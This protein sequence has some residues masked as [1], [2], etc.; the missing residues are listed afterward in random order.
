MSQNKSRIS[1]KK[2]LRTIN[3]G[4]PSTIKYFKDKIKSI[5]EKT[6]RNLELTTVNGSTI[7]FEDIDKNAYYQGKIYRA[8]SGSISEIKDIEKLEIYD[9]HRGKLLSEAY[10]NLI[11]GISKDDYKQANNAFNKLKVFKFRNSVTPNNGNVICKDGEIHKITI[12]EQF[13]I[14]AHVLKETFEQFI[15]DKAFKDEDDEISSIVLAEDIELK[16]TLKKVPSKEIMEVKIALERERMKKA[17]QTPEFVNLIFEVAKL[18]NEDK[19]EEAIIKTSSY[20]SEEQTLLLLTESELIDTIGYALATKG[21]FNDTIGYHVANVISE[22]GLQTNKK[23][24][25]DFW[26]DVDAQINNKKIKSLIESLHQNNFDE[27]YVIMENTIGNLD[28]KKDLVGVFINSILSFL[29]N[30]NLTKLVKTGDTSIEDIKNE[31]SDLRDYIEDSDTNEL[32]DSVVVKLQEIM[33][34]FD[35]LNRHKSLI[36]F[37]ETIAPETEEETGPEGEA[38]EIP[39]EEGAAVGMGAGLTGAPG[40]PAIGGDDEFEIGGEEEAETKPEEEEEEEELK[41]GESIK[42]LRGKLKY[43]KENKEEC[44]GDEKFHDEIN[45]HINECIE[46]DNDGIEMLQEFTTLREEY[47]TSKLSP[48]TQKQELG[49]DEFPFENYSDHVDIL[50]IEEI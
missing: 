5:G 23:D 43:I 47:V 3:S 46:L 21:V 26:Q 49:R 13:N 20:I 4:M 11:E 36:N 44:F 33:V 30:I 28:M 41:M 45:K 1:I 42:H 31:F 32:D 15:E 8:E 18:I 14:N 27:Y 39:A 35:I 38:V 16:E 7:I 34:P 37:D 17:Y 40:A 29:N 6:N 12:N 2:F 10:D 48:K 9:E 25:I 50:D 19:L 24:M 22:T